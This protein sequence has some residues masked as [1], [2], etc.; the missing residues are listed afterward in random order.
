M[1]HK[2][3]VVILVVVLVGGIWY[4]LS[5][6]TPPA[7]LVSTSATASTGSPTQDSANEELVAT[8]LTLRAVTLSGTIFQ[9]PAFTTLRD[10]GTA[11]V[12]EPIGRQNPFAPYISTQ[13]A[14]SGAAGDAQL[15]NQQNQ[16][17]QNAQNTQRRN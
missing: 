3:V 5:Q 9:D 1:Q 7:P 8:L 6:N 12:A 14:S 10:F 17:P 15:F 16:A 2:L 13:G 4:G 11:I